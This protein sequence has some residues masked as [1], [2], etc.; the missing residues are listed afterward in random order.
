M[1]ELFDMFDNKI[2][3][4]KTA[5]IMMCTILFVVGSCLINPM[6]LLYTALV[7]LGIALLYCIFLIIYMFVDD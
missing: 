2:A 6:I 7:A 1:R 4:I 5:M 3:V